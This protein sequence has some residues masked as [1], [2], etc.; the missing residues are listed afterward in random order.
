M[1]KVIKQGAARGKCLNQEREVSEYWM[2]ADTEFDERRME[3]MRKKLRIMQLCSEGKNVSKEEREWMNKPV[4]YLEIL[5]GPKYN[6]NK[7]YQTDVCYNGR[8]L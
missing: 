3:F 6:S 8:I 4:S 5:N 1:A 7:K 2:I